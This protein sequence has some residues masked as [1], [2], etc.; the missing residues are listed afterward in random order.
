MSNEQHFE[1]DVRR[2]DD[3]SIDFDFYRTRSIALRR[4][5]MR[6]SLTLRTASAGALVMAGAVGFAIVI[7]SATTPTLGDRI[8]TTFSSSSQTR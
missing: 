1:Q 4:Q 3:N 8:A 7:P 5:A 6:D 2:H